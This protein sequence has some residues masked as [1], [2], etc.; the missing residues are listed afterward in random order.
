M[1]ETKESIELL[2]PAW[3]KRHGY[4]KWHQTDDDAV[5]TFLRNH[6]SIMLSIGRSHPKL[7]AVEYRYRRIGI[8]YSVTR[9]LADTTVRVLLTRMPDGVISVDFR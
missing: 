4:I 8:G 3:A 6:N 2:M 5:R 1:V 7:R 9:A